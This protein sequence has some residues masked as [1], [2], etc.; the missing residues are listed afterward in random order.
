[1][2][3][4]AFDC[5]QARIEKPRRIRESC[6]AAPSADPLGASGKIVRFAHR[7]AASLCTLE[8]SQAVDTLFGTTLCNSPCA[9]PT[10]LPAS[11]KGLLSETH[12]LFFF[13]GCFD[14]FARDPPRAISSAPLRF[15]LMSSS[16]WRRDLRYVMGPKTPALAPSSFRNLTAS[17]RHTS[18]DRLL[19][20]RLPALRTSSPLRLAPSRRNGVLRSSSPHTGP[21]SRS[22]VRGKLARGS[23]SSASCT[24]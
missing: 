15:G 17:T 6:S 12:G 10:F 19:P 8:H 3:L 5:R 22:C 13:F 21:N 7:P 23:R 20:R 16:S 4:R 14:A 11:P 1:M 18:G 9:L 2:C 24:C